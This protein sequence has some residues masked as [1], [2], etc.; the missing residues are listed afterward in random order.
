MADALCAASEA[1][2]DLDRRV[3]GSAVDWS[4]SWDEAFSD[5][6][7]DRVEALLRN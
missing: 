1:A 5:D 4:R 7:M 3:A 6:V 2:G